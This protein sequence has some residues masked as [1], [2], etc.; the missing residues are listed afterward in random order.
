MNWPGRGGPA[1]WQ[2][3]RSG[4]GQ[5]RDLTPDGVGES[6]ARRGEDMVEEEGKEPGRYDSGTGQV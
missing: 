4:G 1:I 6:Q 2:E 3:H 5:D